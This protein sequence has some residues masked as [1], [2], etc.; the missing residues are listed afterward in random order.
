MKEVR[1][2]A[3]NYVDD[4]VARG[5]AIEMLPF[6][7]ES[8][9]YMTLLADRVRDAIAARCSAHDYSGIIISLKRRYRKEIYI[10]LAF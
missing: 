4:Q 9:E 10:S 2:F 1:E 5:F 7:L 8:D 6:G 3:K